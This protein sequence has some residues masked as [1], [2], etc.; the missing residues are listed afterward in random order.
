VD[1]HTISKKTAELQ[2]LRAQGK[3]TIGKGRTSK[4]KR[5]KAKVAVRGKGTEKKS[6]P[7]LKRVSKMGLIRTMTGACKIC[8]GFWSGKYRR[9]ERQGECGRG[10]INEWEPK[11]KKASRQLSR[12]MDTKEH[13]IKKR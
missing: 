5:S 13:L 6:W 1:E 11:R 8:R 9:R 10:E 7:T 12:S 3:G 2:L 4:I